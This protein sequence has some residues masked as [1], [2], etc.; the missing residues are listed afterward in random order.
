MIQGAYD[1]D[2][3]IVKNYTESQYPDILKQYFKTLEKKQIDK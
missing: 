1:E 2:T 3:F